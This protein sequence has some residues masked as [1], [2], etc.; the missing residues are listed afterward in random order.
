MPFG[1]PISYVFVPF[2]MPQ[3]TEGT[4]CGNADTKD[5]NRKGFNQACDKYLIECTEFGFVNRR[6]FNRSRMRLDV[7][8]VC[9]STRSLICH[10]T[11][12]GCHAQEQI[13]HP[14]CCPCLI[15]M[16]AAVIGTLCST[17]ETNRLSPLWAAHHCF[18]TL[19][20][21]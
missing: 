12:E 6:V 5:A 2:I 10:N 21:F 13:A 7:R 14:L 17:A 3:H 16:R 1:C 18:S 19:H 15:T 20:Y 8:D 11:E 4:D 9:R